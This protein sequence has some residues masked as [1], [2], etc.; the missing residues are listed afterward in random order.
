MPFGPAGRAG[1]QPRQPRRSP[2]AHSHWHLA[3]CGK[4]A[5][6]AALRPGSERC[7]P[8][9]ARR[10]PPP[11]GAVPG[12]PGQRCRR[13]PRAR[14]RKVTT[15]GHPGSCSS[16]L[17]AEVKAQLPRDAPLNPEGT[18]LWKTPFSSLGEAGGFR[19][20][21]YLVPFAGNLVRALAPRK[22]PAGFLRLPTWVLPDGPPNSGPSPRS[23]VF[24][25]RGIRN[26]RGRVPASC[27]LWAA[28]WPIARGQKVS[29]KE[30]RGERVRRGR[31]DVTRR[32]LLTPK[33]RAGWGCGNRRFPGS[34]LR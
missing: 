8:C 12:L 3:G 25:L 11:A 29:W 23:N 30:R 26:F 19:P 5:P 18:G 1:S 14:P 20:G 10:G 6:T 13:S 27:L 31:G 4:P 7:N 2:L 24:Y 15:H 9:A 16:R 21:L 22:P 34:P 33:R 28:I 17:P 32:T